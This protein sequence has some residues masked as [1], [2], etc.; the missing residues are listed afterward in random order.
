[1]RSA[2]RIGMAIGLGLAVG[3][4]TVRADNPC[5]GDARETF[6]DCKGDCK[7]AYQVAKDQCRNKD[8][9]CMEGCRA[10]RAECVLNTTL[11]EELAACRDTLRAAKDDCRTTHAGDDAAI[12][13]CIDAA[14]VTAFLCRK[15]AR[16]AAKPSILACRAGF[17]AC[18]QVCPVNPDNN[19]NIDKVQCKL[20]AKDAYLDCKAGCREEFQEQKDLCLNRDHDCV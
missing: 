7:E 6:T 19:E 10:G 9:D 8:H 11:D 4:T 14:Q 12:D 1:M 17:R 13:Q 18:A 2:L 16:K 15:A 5:I 20:D 3:A